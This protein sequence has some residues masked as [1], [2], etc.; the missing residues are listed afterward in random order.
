MRTHICKAIN[1]T[2]TKSLFDDRSESSWHFLSSLALQ[3]WQQKLLQPGAAG[4]KGAPWDEDSGSYRGPAGELPFESCGPSYIP[5]PRPCSS[6]A[7]AWAA[8]SLDHWTL[9]ACFLAF[10]ASSFKRGGIILSS[11]QDR[12]WPRADDQR[13]VAERGPPGGAGGDWQAT[14]RV[15]GTLGLSCCPCHLCLIVTEA[16]ASVGAEGRAEP[17]LPTCL[18]SAALSVL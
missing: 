17:T 13:D 7:C 1:I 15:G 6:P 16:Q 18:P 2:L 10:S 3:G 12:R 8:P 4:E 14:W 5:L 11:T 9:I